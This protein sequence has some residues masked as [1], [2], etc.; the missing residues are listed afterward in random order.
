MAL[1]WVV[2]GYA[3]GAKM[4]M[5]LFL[6]YL[7]CDQ[8]YACTPIFKQ[9]TRTHRDAKLLMT[10]RFLAA[11]LVLLLITLALVISSKWGLIH[12]G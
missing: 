6:T 12:D 9:A 2:L 7:T 3:T 10:W 1:E 8:E 11:L 4:I 5:L